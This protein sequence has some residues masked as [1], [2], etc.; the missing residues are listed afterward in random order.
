MILVTGATGNVGNQVARILADK[1]EHVRVLTRNSDGANFPTGIQVVRGDFIDP[2]T[3]ENATRD[4]NGIFLMLPALDANLEGAVKRAAPQVD[5]I[6]FLSTSL[7][8]TEGASSGYTVQ[9]HAAIEYVVKNSGTAWTIVRP[10]FFAANALRMWLPQLRTGDVLRWPYANARFAPIHERDIAEIA[11]RGLLTNDHADK[12]YTV[13][14][15]AA[16]TASEQLA[17]IG[18]HARR[19]LHFEEVNADVARQALSFL[20]A[21]LIEGLLA[22][23]ERATHVEPFLTDTVARVLGKPA[24]TFEEWAA[25]HAAAFAK[26]A[27]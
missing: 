18:A 1:G 24:R 13:T 9:R 4:A 10:G 15:P 19:S 20:P 25:D 14:G 7:V 11:V 16:I 2:A 27:A 5:R 8:T 26:S 21:P 23:W 6:V 3:L 22:Q 12:V 17:I